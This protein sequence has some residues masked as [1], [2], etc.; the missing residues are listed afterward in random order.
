VQVAWDNDASLRP[1]EDAAVE[2][3]PTGP[4]AKTLEECRPR[5][6]G[7]CGVSWTWTIVPRKAGEQIL[8]LTVRPR[9][10][11]DGRLA[12]DFQRRNEDIA[13]TVEVHP[14]RAAFRMATASLDDL[15]LDVPAEATSG[16]PYVVTAHFPRSWGG[17]DIV[18]SDLV[19]ART[20]DS[21]PAVLTPV[22]GSAGD[23]E[24]TRSWRVTPSGDGVM[25]LS[26]TATV[27]AQAGD[28]PLE[29]TVTRSV[30]LPVA[31]SFWDSVDAR[32]KWLGGIVGLL[33]GLFG[34]W[35]AAQRFRPGSRR[36]KDGDAGS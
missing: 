12:E 28:V 31:P 27:R 13:I 6:S 16:E 9:V 7:G 8:L 32:V 3:S 4:V 18:A 23:D 33:L 36:A 22:S 30:S 21:P 11:I 25:T 14:A 34:L 10:F 5:P 29:K 24:V 19:L 15:V 35:T 1:A 17:S 26:V 20:P 2:V